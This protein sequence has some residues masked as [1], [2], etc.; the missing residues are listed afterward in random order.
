MDN[1]LVSLSTVAGIIIIIGMFFTF[2]LGYLQSEITGQEKFEPKYGKLSLDTQNPIKVGILHSLTGTM[3]ISETPV[4][5]AT[6]LAIDEINNQG[7]LLGFLISR[8][9]HQQLFLPIL[10]FLI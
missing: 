10:E 4:V 7:G 9:L 3:A 5:D 8:T 2:Q 1:R 6:L